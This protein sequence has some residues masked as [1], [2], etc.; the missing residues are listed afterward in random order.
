MRNPTVIV[1]ALGLMPQVARA[2]PSSDHQ[3]LTRSACREAALPSAFCSRL[4]VSAYN[5]EALEVDDPAAHARRGDAQTACQAAEAVEARVRTL[6]R[7][8]RAQVERLARARDP[9]IV[10]DVADLLGRALHTVQDGCVHAGVGAPQH[11]FIALS[12]T[13][14]GT[15]MSPDLE[16][17]GATCASVETSLAIDAFLELLARSGLSAAVLFEVGSDRTRWPSRGA[18]CA[19]LRSAYAWD[20]KDGRWNVAV[21][22]PRF[23]DQLAHALL[24][25]DPLPGSACDPDPARLDP[26][27]VAVPVPGAGL[28]L[29]WCLTVRAYCEGQ[30]DAPPPWERAAPAGGAAGCAT[31]GEAGGGWL[32]LAGLLMVWARARSGAAD[33]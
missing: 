20:G 12:A 33:R 25:S 32:L 24:E 26:V 29:D 28:A 23:R 14:A 8:V 3:Q 17:P 5:V 13:C 19:H 21:M 27:D 4:A 22:V 6:G 31:T 2:L 16:P 30:V 1:L 11:A 7:Q 18:V 9:A 10:D 15:A